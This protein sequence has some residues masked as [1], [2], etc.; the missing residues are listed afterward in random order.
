MDDI[1]HCY[2]MTHIPILTKVTFIHVNN[3]AHKLLSPNAYFEL[4]FDIYKKTWLLTL[5]F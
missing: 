2:A 4:N 5:C 1:Q 3:S